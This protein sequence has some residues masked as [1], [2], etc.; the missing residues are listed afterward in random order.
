MW[1]F[2]LSLIP[3]TQGRKD[4]PDVLYLG[5]C[6]VEWTSGACFRKISKSW[7]KFDLLQLSES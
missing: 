1:R 3:I 7:S 6:V 4:A 5:E 2:V